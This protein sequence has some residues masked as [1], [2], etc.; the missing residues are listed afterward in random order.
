MQKKNLFLIVMTHSEVHIQCV[1]LE[2]EAPVLID[3]VMPNARTTNMETCNA[4]KVY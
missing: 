2:P 1:H 3:L 4:K